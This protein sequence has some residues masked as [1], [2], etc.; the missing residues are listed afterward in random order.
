MKKFHQKS[1]AQSNLRKIQSAA[2][3]KGPEQPK[4]YNPD[5]PNTSLNIPEDFNWAK[6]KEQFEEEG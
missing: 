4:E 2:K 5:P 3:Y 1:E 6:L